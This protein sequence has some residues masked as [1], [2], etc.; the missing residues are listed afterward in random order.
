MKPIPKDYNLSW[1]CVDKNG[2][3][4]LNKH[5]KA[6]I[7][8][9]APPEG[10]PL[11]SKTMTYSTLM[12]L[13]NR[14]A[15]GFSSLGLE[16]GDRIVLRLPNL[17]EFPLNFLGAIKAGL[18]PIPTFP[19]FRWRELKFIL[20]DSRARAIV[21]TPDLLPPEIFTD[22]PKDL[23]DILLISPKGEEL[24]SESQ[25]WQDLIT[26]SSASFKG[27]PT[28][29]E[30]PAYWLYTSGT[31][32]TPKAVIH[33]H[34]SIP[35]HDSRC[36]KWLD[37]RESDVIFNTSNLNWSYALT[38]G[39]LDIFRHSL[40]T[41]IYHGKLDPEKICEII[42]RFHV[43][44]FMSVPGIYR[45]LAR[46]LTEHPRALEGVRS[47]L[48]SG[49]NLKPEVRKK[50]EAA[51]H[52]PIREGLGMTENSVFLVQSVDKPVIPGSLG[53]PTFP[54]QI[55]ILDKD[56]NPAKPG[57]IGILATRKDCP[58]LM[59]GY[60]E[61]PDE[62]KEAF[63]GDWFLSGDLVYKDEAENYF[64]VGRRDDVITAGGFRVSP[65]E[66][67]KVL[68]QHPWVE[69]S[70]VVASSPGPD[71]TLVQAFIVLTEGQPADKDTRAQILTFA[72]K[73]LAPYKSPREISFLKELP[74]TTTG[75]IKRQELK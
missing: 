73:N 61:R 45:R 23:K 6:L 24:P 59:L 40:T 67:E 4:L 32:G 65:I 38:A 27:V 50:V 42:R 18:I 22:R 44:T 7:S 9:T 2:V 47:I 43:A 20:E 31:T 35:A 62:S 49:E 53:Q 19:Q 1:D 3:S 29:S 37:V 58:G 71:K 39:M 70:A 57:E 12:G 56:F 10:G 21:S 51:T 63:Q 28:N 25:R 26:N 74:K 69:E 75:K 5:K 11:Q 60:F 54:E 14:V 46:H 64:F 68:N 16:R 41:V 13:T 52:I 17:P 30:D 66:V 8:V 15:N 36:Q 48:C 55:E 72:K 33:A 34:R